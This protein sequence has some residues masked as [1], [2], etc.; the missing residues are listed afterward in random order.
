YDPA[1]G[2]WSSAGTFNFARWFHTATLLPN[3][4]VL[5]AGGLG[6]TGV[7]TFSSFNSAELYDPATGT[8]SLTGNLN[9]G[10]DGHTA[11]LLQSGK[12]LVAEGSNCPSLNDC[13]NLK[14]AEIYD[15]A[16]G[17]WSSTGNLN[18]FSFGPATLLQNGKV[19]VIGGGFEENG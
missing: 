11:T 3:G 16:T 8:W 17:T 2:T 15:P 19:L 7:N 18:I 5:I 6:P 12:V 1:T 13:V 9:T 14:S 10:R 4:K